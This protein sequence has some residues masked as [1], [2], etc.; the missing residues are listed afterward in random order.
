MKNRTSEMTNLLT[1]AFE[2]FWSRQDNQVVS[3]HNKSPVCL[4]TLPGTHKHMAEGQMLLDILVKDLDSKTLSVELDHLA[5]AH[6]EL[7]GDQESGFLG[8]SFGNKEEHGSDL[9]QID[10]SFGDLELSLSGNVHG[11]VHPR[12]LGQVTDDRF[13]AV[14][15]QNTIALD[16]SYKRPA[17]FYDRNKNGSAGIP[18]VHQHG[19]GGMNL[20]AKILK[21]FQSQLNFAFESALEARRLGAISSHAPGQPLSSHLQDTSHGALAI[22]QAIGGMVNAQAF[23]FLAFSGA[24]SIVD[25]DQHFF[26]TIGQ[27]GDL[28][29]MG[30]LKTLELLGRAVQKALQIVGKGLSKLAG[31]FSSGMKLDKPNQPHDIKQKVFVLGLCQNAQETFQIGRNL[32]REMFSHGFRALL[33]CDSIGDFG[34][35]PFVLKWLLSSVT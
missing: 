3:D 34:R 8:S 5:F 11:L 4:N 20:P 27:R 16:R 15:L 24:S 13:L 21:G 6:T 25:N 31:D 33:G 18:A 17:C 2:M 23:D 19:Y 9:G 29:L 22:D 12:S 28:F 10:N 35:K 26:G 7:V 14:D 32:F 30:V 1:K